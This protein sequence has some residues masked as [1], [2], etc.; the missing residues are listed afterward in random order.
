MLA[1]VL[2][3][4]PLALLPAA[5]LADHFGQVV[6]TG[7]ISPIRIQFTC[8]KAE[9]AEREGRIEEAER[10][11]QEA[12]Q[13]PRTPA[14]P[15]HALVHL[16]YG[17]FLQRRGR[18]PEAVD[19]WKVALAG[20]LQPQQALIT[21]MRGADVLTDL[22]QPHQALAMLRQIAMPTLAASE[23][24]ALQERMAALQPPPQVAH[25]ALSS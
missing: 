17:N 19:E 15:E 25:Q 3:A 9:R 6:T 4:P 18:L 1:C 14:R 5:F 16:H 13:S 24:K 20:E 12:L 10:F 21:A 22:G 11:Y 23:A 2:L 7:A 8:G